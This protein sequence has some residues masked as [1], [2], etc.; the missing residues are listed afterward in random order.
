MIS[1]SVDNEDHHD[2]ISTNI[3]EPKKNCAT[4]MVTMRVSIHAG[5]IVASN[6]NSSR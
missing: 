4:M 5:A 3:N 1:V 6:E 2:D